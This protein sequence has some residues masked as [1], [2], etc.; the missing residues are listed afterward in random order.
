M[1]WLGTMA[2]DWSTG[3]RRKACTELAAFHDVIAD[4]KRKTLG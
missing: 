1:S 4:K 2:A 3:H